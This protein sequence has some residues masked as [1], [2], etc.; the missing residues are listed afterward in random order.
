MAILT[1]QHVSSQIVSELMRD[2]YDAL[3]QF[4]EV[5]LSVEKEILSLPAFEWVTTTF[6]GHPLKSRKGDNL[7]PACFE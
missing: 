2:L 7:F 1:Q 6:W 3:K 4:H 5:R